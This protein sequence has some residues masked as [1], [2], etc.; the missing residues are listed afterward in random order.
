MPKRSA[1]YMARRRDDILGALFACVR[2]RGWDRTTMDDVAAEAGLSK[3]AVY[4]H[5]ESKRALLIGLLEQES[6]AVDDLADIDSLEKLRD[7]LMRNVALLSQAD[8]WILAT[9]LK[10]VQVAAA[11]D[12]EIRE[13]LVAVTERMIAFFAAVAARL[14]PGLA[15]TEARRRACTLFLLMDGMNTSRSYCD[16]LTQADLQAIV[17]GQLQALA[18]P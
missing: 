4:V 7:R 1:D 16:S 8:G 2:R 17:D 6:R 15:K 9:A 11:Y 12:P 5:F 3:G 13:R 18:S 10:E 14:N